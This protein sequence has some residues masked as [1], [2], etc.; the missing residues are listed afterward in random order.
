MPL[1]IIKHNAVK[2]YVRAE[3][4]LH[5]FL[6]LVLDHPSGRSAFSLGKVLQE[7]TGKE[8][9]QASE[10]VWP[11]WSAQKY[12][13]SAGNRTP[14]DQLRALLVCIFSVRK[15]KPSRA[16]IYSLFY[17]QNFPH[18]QHEDVRSKILEHTDTETY[19]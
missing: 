2:T 14:V 12:L 17:K 3:V 5:L 4:E 10:P 6:T 18:V 13:V 11:Q 9:G 8:D 19:V 7:P 1:V 16:G 15:C